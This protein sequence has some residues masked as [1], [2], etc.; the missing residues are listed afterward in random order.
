VPGQETEKYGKPKRARHTRIK[1]LN[2]FQTRENYDD[3]DDAI[4]RR[5]RNNTHVSL[6]S[7]DGRRPSAAQ[8]HRQDVSWA[9]VRALLQ[10]QH[11]V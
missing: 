8:L 2:D 11:V 3:V 4:A 10:A 6:V 9:A 1:E 7:G 5:A